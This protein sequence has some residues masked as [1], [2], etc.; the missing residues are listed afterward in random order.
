MVHSRLIEL[1]FSE[2][3]SF[4][5]SERE[6]VGERENVSPPDQAAVSYICLLFTLIAENRKN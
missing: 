3:H 5:K 4:I 1:A 6:R 2:V